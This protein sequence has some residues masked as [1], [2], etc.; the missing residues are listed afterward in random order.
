VVLA[1]VEVL[2]MKLE[3]LLAVQELLTKVTLVVLVIIT[4]EV[5]VVAALDLLDL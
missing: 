3:L 2:Q 5:V 4:Q 1:E